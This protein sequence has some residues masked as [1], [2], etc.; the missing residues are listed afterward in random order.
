M[1]ETWIVFKTESLSAHGWEERKLLPSG[2]L[3]DV[4]ATEWDFSGKLPQIGDRVREYANLQDP[5]NG[6]THGKDGDWIVTRINQFSSQET[7]QEIAVC[8]CAYQPIESNWVELKRGRPVNE[9]LQPA[10]V[11]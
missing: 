10:E 3:T 6:I 8:Y 2:G 5:D 1:N 4:L 7:N 11:G 9:I